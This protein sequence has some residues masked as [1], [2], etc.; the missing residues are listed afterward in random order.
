MPI[1]PLALPEVKEIKTA[2]DVGFP[3]RKQAI[4]PG[5]KSK[6]FGLEDV[7]TRKQKMDESKKSGG[8]LKDINGKWAAAKVSANVAAKHSYLPPL[9][10]EKRVMLENQLPPSGSLKDP[11]SGKKRKIR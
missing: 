7:P 4:I 2:Q 8:V 3:P 6:K 5:K 10:G 11:M 1:S 9:P